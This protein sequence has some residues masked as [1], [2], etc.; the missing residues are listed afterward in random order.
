[1]PQEV[2]DAAVCILFDVSGSMAYEMNN[3]MSQLQVL[4]ESFEYIGVDS[5]V[6]PFSDDLYVL[7]KWGQKLNCW[8]N[9]ADGT[10]ATDRAAILALNTIKYRNARNKMCIIIT[11]GSPDYYEDTRI[12][13]EELSKVCDVYTV[14]IGAPD[15]CI[16]DPEYIEYFRNLF[17]DNFC[18][19]KD[20][21]SLNKV[22]TPKIRKSL[23]K[24]M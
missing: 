4:V 23:R 19:S 17:G 13:I 5:C 14:L 8:Y 15:W 20:V 6:I 22:L 16:S 2:F 9:E 12:A 18:T 7:K 21:S 3:A 24:W 11:D 10:T 1:M